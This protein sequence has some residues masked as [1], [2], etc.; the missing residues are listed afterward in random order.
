MLF[1]LTTMNSS[2]LLKSA[3]EIGLI[4]IFIAFKVI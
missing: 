3:G 4:I 2:L 1:A